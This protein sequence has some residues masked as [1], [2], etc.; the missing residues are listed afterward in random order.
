MEVDSS[1]FSPTHTEH[2]YCISTPL[3]LED[4]TTATMDTGLVSCNNTLD[5][6]QNI[7]P[8][9]SEITK[10]R[11]EINELKEK[12]NMKTDENISLK[13]QLDTA[14]QK[15][16]EKDEKIKTTSFSWKSIENKN[17]VCQM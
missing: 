16:K 12:I 8:E 13:K 15:I 11:L 10:L 9:N 4:F 17:T 14:K 1:L 5:N 2:N 6:T 7:L 3:P